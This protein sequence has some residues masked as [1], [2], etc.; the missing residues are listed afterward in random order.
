ME[1]AAR[2]IAA[3]DVLAKVII[4]KYYFSLIF[5]LMADRWGRSS[6][7]GVY[8]Q[9]IFSNNIQKISI[10]ARKIQRQNREY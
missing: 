5:K 2:E 3:I 8:G 7:K 6:T 1:N 9:S 4:W 10:L